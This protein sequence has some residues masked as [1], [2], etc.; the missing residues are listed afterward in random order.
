[1][2]WVALEFV[3]VWVF[4]LFVVGRAILEFKL[5][6]VAPPVELRVDGAHV[7]WPQR[8]QLDIDQFGFIDLTWRLWLDWPCCLRRPL[9]QLRP[10]C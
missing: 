6:L 10:A 4:L 1:M 7:E 2:E 3:L 5:V 9:G 8:Q